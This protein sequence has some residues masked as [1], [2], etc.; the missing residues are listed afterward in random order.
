MSLNCVVLEKFCLHLQIYNNPQLPYSL[1]QNTAYH[2]TF[3]QEIL[4][5]EI[6]GVMILSYF[7]EVPAT[8]WVPSNPGPV[9]QTHLFGT[10]CGLAKRKKICRKKKKELWME[11]WVWKWAERGFVHFAEWAEGEQRHFQDSCYCLREFNQSALFMKNLRESHCVYHRNQPFESVKVLFKLHHCSTV[12]GLSS[13]WLLMVSAWDSMGKTH[14]NCI[15]HVLLGIREAELN[16]RS[17]V[18]TESS[19]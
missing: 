18:K 3:L 4:S 6:V 1:H 14:A 8:T 11:E 16:N 10:D 12:V 2:S 7:A 19:Q 9:T 15:Y 13:H 5:F 17:R